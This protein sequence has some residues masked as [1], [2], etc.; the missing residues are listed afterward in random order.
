MK[1][2]GMFFKQ[3][4]VLVWKNSILKIRN[5]RTLLL[6]LSIPVAVVLGMW[7]LRFGAVKPVTAK[8]SLPSSIGVYVPGFGDMYSG[9][10]GSGQNLVWK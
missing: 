8:T 7:A 9:V 2:S 10:C 3:F 4:T 1:Q 6:E 5:W